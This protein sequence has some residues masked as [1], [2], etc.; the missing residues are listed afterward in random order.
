MLWS[1]AVAALIRCLMLLTMLLHSVF[2]CTW[3]HFHVCHSGHPSVGLAAEPQ[4]PI[5]NSHSCACH[6]KHQSAPS[7]SEKPIPNCDP[8]SSDSVPCG[9]SSGCDHS[10]CSF[11][12]SVPGNELSRWDVLQVCIV[13]EPAQAPISGACQRECLL[14]DS[15]CV[16]LSA[17]E[18]CARL[19]V[20]QI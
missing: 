4:V 9:H 13:A 15:K 12:A 18:F 20:W 11:T 6:H 2:G 16:A 1:C 10:V 7:G 19:Q 3:H 5:A 8:I 17:P 14:P